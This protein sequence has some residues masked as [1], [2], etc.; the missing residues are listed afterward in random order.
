MLPVASGTR[1]EVI[2]MARR[3]AVYSGLLLPVV[4]LIAGVALD[5]IIEAAAVAVVVL[6]IWAWARGRLPEP[7]DRALG[8]DGDPRGGVS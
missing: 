1:T 4:V 8:R 3:A 7:D 5:R 6:A 2:V